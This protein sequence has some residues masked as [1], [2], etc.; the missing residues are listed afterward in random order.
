[1]RAATEEASHIRRQRPDVRSA[2]ASNIE[3]DLS[4]VQLS[5]RQ[6]FDPDGTRLARNGLALARQPIQTDARS[7]QRRKHRR[8]LLQE[9]GEFLLQSL[10][11]VVSYRRHPPHLH[12]VFPLI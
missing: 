5:E 10:E 7:L 12:N 4:A 9:T 1:M 2:R 8:D 11:F 6:R 3:L